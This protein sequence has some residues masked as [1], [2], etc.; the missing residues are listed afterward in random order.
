MIETSGCLAGD[1][2][3]VVAAMREYEAETGRAAVNVSGWEVEDKQIAPPPTLVRRLR[4]LRPRLAGYAYARDFALAKQQAAEV[5]GATIRHGGAPVTPERVAILQNSTQGLLLAL[6]ALK[7]RGVERV[8]VAAPC[9]YAVAEV[10]RHLELAIEVVP[11]RDFITG[12]L[13]SERIVR[14]MRGGR[15]ALLLTNPAFSL[16]VE[17][18]WETIRRLCA[19]LPYSAYVLLD[20]T[21]L[22]LNWDTPLPWYAA[23]YSDQV[24]ALRSPSKLFFLN[25]LKTSV[26]LGAP[27]VVRAVERLGDAL[28]GS[29]AGNGEAV[30]L[31]YLDCWRDWLEEARTGR[32]GAMLQW[33][34]GVVARLRRNRLVFTEALHGIGFTLSPVDSGPYMLAALP[35]HRMPRL[36]S[37]TLARS[38]GVLL[39]DSSYFCHKSVEWVGF[40]V[41]LAGDAERMRDALLRLFE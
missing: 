31:A 16:G 28:I 29:S 9:Y 34:G 14:A 36:D 13:D 24:V 21:R 32:N 10:C 15:A 27:E 37:R 18:G 38:A 23:E 3:P 11:A 33:R 41:N 20:E 26:L 40:R 5:F 17:Y 8:V 25:G 7:E 4:A 19:A 35:R 22:G 6:C 39:M 1:F 30:A 12:A 2:G